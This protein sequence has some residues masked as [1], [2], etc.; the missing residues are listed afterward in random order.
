MSILGT[1]IDQ[2]TFTRAASALSNS[3]TFSTVAHSLPSTPEMV[4]VGLNSIQTGLGAAAGRAEV[5]VRGSTS[6][7][8][9]TLAINAPTQATTPILSG[10]LT[11]F[12]FHSVIR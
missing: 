7:G 3:A 5:Y 10:V 6:G 1:L 12:I 9:N 11:S 2:T 4:H 8:I